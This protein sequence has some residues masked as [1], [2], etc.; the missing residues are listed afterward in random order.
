MRFFE[1]LFEKALWNG[2]FVV[3]VAVVARWDMKSLL[4]RRLLGA[5]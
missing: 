3:V 5:P 1:R 4:A 2:R